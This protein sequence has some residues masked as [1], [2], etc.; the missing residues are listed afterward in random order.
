MYGP[1]ICPT[2]WHRTA[3]GVQSPC[4]GALVWVLA[5]IGARGNGKYLEPQL[6]I[7]ARVEFVQFFDA[8]LVVGSD[9]VQYGPLHAQLQ[10]G[11]RELGSPYMGV[12]RVGHNSSNYKW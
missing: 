2:V 9:R 11:I 3:V 7:K 12:L 8:S 10:E 5:P 6:R 1:H 4:R